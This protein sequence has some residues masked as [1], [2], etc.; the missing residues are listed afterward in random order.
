VSEPESKTIVILGAGFGGVAA[1]QELA[2]L[3]PENEEWD[4]V[5]VDQNNFL[6]FTPM[7]TEVAGGVVDA[8]GI[9]SAV[10]TLSSRVTFEQGRVTS[11]DAANGQ[12]EI[13]IGESLPGVQRARKVIRAEHLVV[14]LGSI[15]NFRGIDG[16]VEHSLT[17]KTIEGALAIRTRTLALLERAD[18]ETDPDA[19]RALLTFVVGGAG[20]SGV[21]TMAVLNDLV[22]AL[23]DK[24]PRIDARDIRTVLVDPGT[25]LL[26][27][28]SEGL[29]QYAQKKLE[30]RGVEMRLQ[31][32]IT[33][34]GE[35]WVE[36]K[37]EH[38]QD[39]ERI[40]THLLV[41][42]GGVTP[43]PV[44]EK[45]GLP[46]GHHHGVVVDGC[47]RVKDHPNM[48]AIG[49]CAEVPRPGGKGTYAP[50][51]QNAT[52]EG[53]LVGGNVAA[54]IQGRP[55][56]SFAYHPIGEL[57]M[58]G[59]QTGVASIYGLHFSGTIAWMMW[60]GIYLAKLPQMRQRVRVVMDWT[61]DLVFGRDLA[62][63]PVP[64]SPRPQP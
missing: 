2:R 34:A 5:L 27:E 18:E 11:I 60:R 15:T 9:V 43:E 46:L 53:K 21:E 54:A 45:S 20:F 8:S 16:L 6:L 7:L 63:I 38:V 23:R 19:R 64:H 10:R 30:Q 13:M 39:K 22:R 25:R 62:T 59:R 61:L 40:P 55:Q 52:R 57:A 3:R 12:V 36:V 14:A 31:T 32:A 58:V 35:G 47:C 24:F 1:A 37:A 50:M 26:P 49:D 17:I 48:W 29:A 41:W 42:A 28:I 33:G 44:I 4:I 51:A 56:R